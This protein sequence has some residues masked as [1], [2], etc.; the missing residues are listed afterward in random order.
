MPTK[1]LAKNQYHPIATR[2]L[3]KAA[4]AAIEQYG[5]LEKA[6]QSLG[7]DDHTISRWCKKNPEYATKVLN[8]KALFGKFHAVDRI[9]RNFLD[10]ALAGPSD[11]QSAVIGMFL[12]KKHDPS[13]RENG[14]GINVNATGPVS[15]VFNLDSHTPT[16]SV[17]DPHNVIDVTSD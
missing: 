1:E 12:S 7:I 6:A 16:S 5:T 13:Y 15:I 8:A 10:R 11:P 14:G 4:L 3:Q 9:E 2:A 17:S